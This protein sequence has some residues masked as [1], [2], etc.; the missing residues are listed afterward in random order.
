MVAKNNSNYLFI[1]DSA[2]YFQI[3]HVLLKPPWKIDLIMLCRHAAINQQFCW[4]K[5][6]SLWWVN[7]EGRGGEGVN[8]N[9]VWLLIMEWDSLDFLCSVNNWKT[10]CRSNHVKLWQREIK[11]I[12]LRS[13]ISRQSNSQIFPSITLKLLSIL[14]VLLEFS[15]FHALKI[16][17]NPKKRNFPRK[18][19]NTLH[20]Q[21]HK[22]KN[23]GRGTSEVY[24][25]KVKGEHHTPASETINK[26]STFKSN[27]K[28]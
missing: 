21:R 5:S 2:V 7:G 28:L 13:E 18:E 23:N 6:F 12:E 24:K 17:K 11:L 3:H 8:S 10:G 19:V 27:K 4:K 14:H 1:L 20:K 26:L 16:K 22:W 25:N 9:L 15:F